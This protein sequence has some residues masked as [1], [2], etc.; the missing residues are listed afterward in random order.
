MNNRTIGL[1]GGTFNPPHKGHL[2]AA[3]EF[4]KSENIDVLY[5]M[6]SYI[7][8]LK[9]MEKGDSPLCRFEMTQKCFDQKY[10]SSTTV[11]VSDFEISKKDLSYTIETVN[12]LL[13]KENTDKIYVFVGSDMFLSLESWK[14]AKELFEK[15]V[16]VTCPREDDVLEEQISKKNVYKDRYNAV[17]HI[18]DIKPLIVSSTQVRKLLDK[19][20]DYKDFC[21]LKNILTESVLWYIIKSGLFGVSFNET[22]ILKQE[23]R[24]YIK[25]KQRLEHIY[26]VYNRAVFLTSF[27]KQEISDFS[28]FLKDVICAALL[29]DVTKEMSPDIQ[30]SL[31]KQYRIDYNDE[32]QAVLHSQTG[33]F[34]AKEHF[35]IN[36]EV[37][38]AIYYHTTGRENMSLLQKII[39]IA[40]YTEESRRLESIA[41]LR[42]EM[43]SELKNGMGIKAIDKAI[44][45]AIESTL[46]FLKQNNKQ[47]DVQTLKTR[48]Y[49]IYNKT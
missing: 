37:F 20:C 23:I 34:F 46:L 42:T 19:A 39:F 22:D 14:N 12:H 8:P 2:R 41:L 15:C 16:F 36:Q 7:T 17:C 30:K 26:G 9:Q 31:C 18:L 49:L 38:D 10:F 5:I 27:F 25:G 3:I 13:Q 11:C 47:I 35:G 40:D 28:S 24:L 45:K 1:L 44:L 33:A 48:D 43:D 32:C 4:C 6:P 29:H 21:M